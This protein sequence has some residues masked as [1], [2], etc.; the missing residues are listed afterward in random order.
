MKINNL[1]WRVCYSD[2][3]KEDLFGQTNYETLTIYIKKQLNTANIERTIMHEILHAYCY[4]YGLMFF[5][6]FNIEQLC[7]FV[8]H[9]FFNLQRLYFSACE[10]L[11]NENRA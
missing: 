10:E 11:E 6:S 1:E 2:N 9:N 3:L 4:S 8:S 7:E 5:E